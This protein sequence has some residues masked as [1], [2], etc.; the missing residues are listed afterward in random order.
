[1]TAVSHLQVLVDA[2]TWV[3]KH[4]AAHF[5]STAAFPVTA[6]DSGKSELAEANYMLCREDIRLKKESR[7]LYLSA[8]LFICFEHWTFWSWEAGRLKEHVV[9]SRRP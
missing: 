6:V 9:A 7:Q 1:M 2:I 4:R 5:D 3:S 8:T